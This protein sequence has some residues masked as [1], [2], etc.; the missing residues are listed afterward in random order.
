METILKINKQYFIKLL[1]GISIIPVVVIGFSTM[2][3]IKNQSEKVSD[4][5]Y[6]VGNVVTIL[7]NYN[8]ELLT[9]NFMNE[10]DQ[11][12]NIVVVDSKGN[13]IY[14]Y[15]A[16]HPEGKMDIVVN[17]AGLE[18]GTYNLRLGKNGHWVSKKFTIQN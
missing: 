13:T 6:P 8:K 2:D 10:K 12:I 11:I 14:D 3:L 5:Y 7:P 17:L 18:K 15:T 16:D 4:S 1:L 9:L